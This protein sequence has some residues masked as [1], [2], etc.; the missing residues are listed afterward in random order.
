M[1]MSMLTL[2]NVS[3]AFDNC[4]LARRLNT[5]FG[6]AD[7]VFQSF[8]TFL[9]NP[10]QC[11]SLFN[12]CSA[13][14]PRN[15][16]DHHASVHGPILLYM[17]IKVLSTIIDLHSITQHSFANDLPLLMSTLYDK[18][19]MLLHSMQSCMSDIYVTSLYTVMYE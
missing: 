1:Y 7:T 2:H 18:I 19:S 5:E 4:D 17:Y 16:R 3:S 6:F 10:T 9:S 12:C 15:S 8:T 13:F 14:A 11:V